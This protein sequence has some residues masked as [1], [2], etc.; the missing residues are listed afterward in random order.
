MLNL[1]SRRAFLQVGAIGIGGANLADLLT[2]QARGAEALRDSERKSVIMIYLPGGPSHIDMF[3]MKPDAPVEIRGEFRAI[4]SKVPGMEMCEKLPLLSQVADKFSIIRGFQTQGSHDG[5]ELS[6]GFRP[7]IYRPAFGSVLSRLEG[8][9][10]PQLPPYI[11]LIEETNLPYHEEPAYLGPAYKPFAI[12]GPGMANLTLAK[13]ISRDQ[14]ADRAAL[15][16]H[17]DTINRDLDYRR[18]MAGLDAFTSRALE[19]ITSSKTRDAFDVSREPLSVRELYGNNP[20]STHF[21]RAR[22]LVEAGVKIVTLCGGWV[23]NGQS[24]SNLSNWD[25]HD[26]NFPRM[27]E[28]LPY[29]DRTLS[30][31]VHD[32]H[33]RGLDKDVIVVAC[34]EM[35]RAP[36]VGVPNPGSNATASGRDHWP[37]GFCWISGGGLK[38]GQVVGETDRRGERSLGRPITVQNLL[39]TLYHTLGIDP[40]MTFLDH[41][42]RPQTL[43]DDQE[44]ILPLV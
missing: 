43:L 29:F 36:R 11:T 23:L 8:N 4:K 39:A 10:R 33:Q 14:L 13:G 35:G 24:A 21:L 2:A 44:K 6:T 28:Q 38:M 32:L 27:R 18:E 16:N 42:G 37:T 30:A 12:R 15:R 25:T 5:K 19:M 17:F 31:L 20:A 7:N 3:D 26:D 22:R 40:A 34:G 41:L 9:E 1:L